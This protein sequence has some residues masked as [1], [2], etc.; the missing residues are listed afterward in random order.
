MLSK[1]KKIALLT[2]GLVGA[3]VTSSAVGVAL[4]SCSSTTTTT[5]EN[6]KYNTYIN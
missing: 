5:D 4:S 1:T 6:T 2:T 3:L